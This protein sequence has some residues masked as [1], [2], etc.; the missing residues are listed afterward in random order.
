MNNFQEKNV[1]FREEVIAYI[2]QFLLKVN[3][4]IIVSNGSLS[5][6]EWDGAFNSTSRSEIQ[7]VP[8]V[9]ITMITLNLDH[10]VVFID[11]KSNEVLPSALDTEEL[12]YVAEYLDEIEI[13]APDRR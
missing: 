10:E 8:E 1:W 11:A 7:V 6:M 4:S 3:R 5:Y 13:D 12:I 2:K 9:E